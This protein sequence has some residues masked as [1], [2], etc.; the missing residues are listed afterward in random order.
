MPEPTKAAPADHAVAKG[1]TLATIGRAYGFADWTA[2]FENEKN[3]ALRATRKHPGAVREGDK[4]HVPER[5]PGAI[6]CEPNRAHSFRLRSVALVSLVLK[7]DECVPFADT[8][9]VLTVD[10]KSYEGTTDAEG[11]LS[12]AVP[13]AARKGELKLFLDP[14]PDAEPVTWALELGAVPPVENDEGLQVRLNR[15]GYPCP[16]TGQMDEATKAALIALQEE[17]GVDPSGALDGPTK[18]AI[19]WLE[20]TLTLEEPA[21]EPPASGR[22]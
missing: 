21:P 7:D 22:E 8:K 12:Q 2:V 16:V 6:E 19:E 13:A 20:L 11:G 1:E 17:S 15:I 9:Y 4:L 14:E 18:Q 5:R 3:A 10:G